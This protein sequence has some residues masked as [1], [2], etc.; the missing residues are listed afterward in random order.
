MVSFVQIRLPFITIHELVCI[1]QLIQF[2]YKLLKLL[3][4]RAHIVTSIRV[5]SYLE[6][7]NKTTREK[8]QAII[9]CG[10]LTVRTTADTATMD[11]VNSFSLNW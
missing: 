9:H 3:E 7:D 4:H 6:N 1:G 10:N 8:K 5:C 11:E 2:K